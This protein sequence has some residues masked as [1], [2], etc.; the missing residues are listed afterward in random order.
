MKRLGIDLMIN[1]VT[2]NIDFYCLQIGANL[3]NKFVYTIKLS[4]DCS[5]LNLSIRDN[6]NNKIF[7]II[8]KDIPNYCFFFR[9]VLISTKRSKKYGLDYDFSYKDDEIIELFNEFLYL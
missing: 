9:K 5:R 4:T 8:A 6:D 2:K 1:A 7:E 3:N